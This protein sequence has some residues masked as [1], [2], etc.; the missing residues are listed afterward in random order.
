MPPQCL[1]LSLGK[2]ASS[3]NVC[4]FSRTLY[5][6]RRREGRERER[7]VPLLASALHVC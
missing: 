4:Y 5:K 1:S 2:S 6:M 3:A 7:E